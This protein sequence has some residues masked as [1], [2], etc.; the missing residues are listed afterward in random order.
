MVPFTHSSRDTC[1]SSLPSDGFAIYRIAR[2]LGS[3]C[4]S[5]GRLPICYTRSGADWID[6]FDQDFYGQRETPSAGDGRPII[7]VVELTWVFGMVWFLLG[8]R[9]GFRALFWV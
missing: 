1:L 4:L 6:A 7:A 3:R 8:L 9:R 2:A 5:S